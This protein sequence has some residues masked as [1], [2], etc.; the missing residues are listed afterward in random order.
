[1]M[2]IMVLMCAR[3]RCCLMPNCCGSSSVDG[4]N[5]C[6]CQDRPNLLLYAELVVEDKC[7]K[8]K[9]DWVGDARLWNISKV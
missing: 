9:K 4:R 7:H 3:Q 2:M 5:F 8:S 6:F 1:M